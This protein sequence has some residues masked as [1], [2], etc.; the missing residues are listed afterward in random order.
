[1]PPKA[2]ILAG[3]FGSR[4]RPLTFSKP[5]PLVELLNKP[6]LLH[7]LEAISKLGVKKI[8]LAVSNF[9]ETLQTFIKQFNQQNG[10]VEVIVSK[11]DYPLGTAGPIKLAEKHL[12][13]DDPIFI[14]NSDIICEF[15]LK[16]LLD[17]H[18][19][20][21]STVTILGFKVENPSRYGVIIPDKEGLVQRFVEKPQTFV[22][23]LINTGVVVVNPRLLELIPENKFCSLE[24]E[25]YPKLVGQ[26]CIY[27]FQKGSFWIDLGIP[28][29]YI[30]GA[31]LYMNY[32]RNT[33]KDERNETLNKLQQKFLKSNIIENETIE[34]ETQQ[35]QQQS[36]SKIIGNVIV[37]QKENSFKIGKGCI[38][39]PNVVL[40]SNVTIGEGCRIFNS[41]ILE[42]VTIG[43]HTLI[44]GSVVG[45]KSKI[46]NWVQ[47]R[48]NSV[49][50][51]DVTVRDN[52]ILNSVSICPNK[53]INTSIWEKTVIL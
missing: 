12:K 13:G 5:K 46:G 21:Q 28:A 49:L 27:C 37:P 50:G 24:R 17:F 20:K 4:L 16:E 36:N 15:P 47:I 48:N 42:N 26:Q 18:I 41:T 34:K 32:L 7:Q 43:N 53:S 40:G 30:L 2:L 44:E 22:G 35:Q 25:I 52:C 8:V 10:T 45:W 51:L 3:G 33:N 1:M 14:V 6:M 11:E 23:N 19:K 39:G 31:Q 9:G 38:L 29:D